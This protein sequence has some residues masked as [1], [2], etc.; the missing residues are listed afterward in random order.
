MRVR[1][2][3]EMCQ[4]QSNA[5]DMRSLSNMRQLVFTAVVGSSGAATNYYVHERFSRVISPVMD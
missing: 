2:S 3:G 5:T 1:T 4:R